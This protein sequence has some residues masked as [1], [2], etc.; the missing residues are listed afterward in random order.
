[1]TVLPREM[2]RTRSPLARQMHNAFARLASYRFAWYLLS[3]F[4]IETLP[5]LAVATVH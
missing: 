2:P 1:M 3:T 4:E 5:P